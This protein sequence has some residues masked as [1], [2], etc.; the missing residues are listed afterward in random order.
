MPRTYEAVY[1]FDSTLE[2]AAINDKISRFHGMLGS[3]EQPEVAY[4]RRLREKFTGIRA[5]Q[6][7]GGNYDYAI[8]YFAALI[9][10]KSVF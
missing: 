8:G 3:T 6:L 7:A 2:D 4:Y 1:I 9:D 5:I 10:D